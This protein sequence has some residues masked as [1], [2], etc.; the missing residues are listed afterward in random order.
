MRGPKLEDHLVLLA[1]V[2]LLAVAALR[3]VPDVDLVAV[4]AGQQDLGID[5]ALNH[6]GR[7]PL[8]RDRRVVAEMPPEVVGEFLGAAVELPAAFDRERIVVDHEDATWGIAVGVTERAHVDAVRA[9]VDGVGS[10]VAGAVGD[11][12]RVDR[13]DELGLLGVGFDV[14]D[15]DA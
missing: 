7:A 10:A 4:L 6:V 5:A 1:E 3:Q 2:D 13:M 11:L 12:F 9:A 14:E 15:V 8:A